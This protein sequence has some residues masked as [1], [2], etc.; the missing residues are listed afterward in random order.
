MV[1]ATQAKRKLGL[2][3]D[4]PRETLTTE[5]SFATAQE[6]LDWL[7][8]QPADMEEVNSPSKVVGGWNKKRQAQELLAGQPAVL[9][10]LKF[11]SASFTAKSQ[12]DH[13][14]MLLLAG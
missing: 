9:Q 4:S 6:E 3:S 5:Q 1:S 13:S 11:I 7:D 12:Q 10:Q 14:Y 8:P 2:C